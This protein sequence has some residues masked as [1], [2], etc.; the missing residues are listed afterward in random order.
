MDASWTSRKFWF[1]VGSWFLVLCV[2]VFVLHTATVVLT[3]KLITDIIWQTVTTGTLT[4]FLMFTGIVLGLYGAGNLTA[5]HLT[6]GK[7]NGSST[8]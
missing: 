1:A 8:P 5:K 6:N 3:K 4:S 7:K 2:Q